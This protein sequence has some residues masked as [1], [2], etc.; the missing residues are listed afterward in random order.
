MAKVGV[1]LAGCGVFDGSEIHEAVC[2]LLALSQAGAEYRCLAPNTPQMHVVDH[3]KG[4]PVPGESRNVL[5]EAA[6]IARGDIVP[7]SDVAV[8]D[9]DAFIFPG[10]FGA[11]KNLCT[12]A[13]E[14]ESCSVQRDV[15]RV[16]REAHAAKK[17]LAFICIAPVIAAKVLGKE[18]GVKLTIGDDPETAKAID[19]MGGNHLTC[20]VRRATVDEEHRI[21]STP[22][23]MKA[24][25]IAEVY[26]GVKWT[27]DE[28]L[29]LIG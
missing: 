27:V 29:K 2:T 8:A 6:R 11:A 19:L 7:L 21:V 14:G 22:A 25:S 5:T 26:E 24:T 4:Q 1:I 9:Y 28:V 12:Y 3:L 10:G 16:I 18:T 13:F 23:Y 20:P 17:P 15:E